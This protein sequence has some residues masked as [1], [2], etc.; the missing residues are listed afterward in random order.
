MVEEQN[1]STGFGVASFVL[2]IISI[3]LFLAPYFSIPL[4]ILGIVFAAI[5]QKKGFTGL[6]VAGIIL[7]SIG[8]ITGFGMT[9]LVIGTLMLGL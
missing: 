1:K 7:N 4:S 6:S 9:V 2:G 3:I 8:L 5:Q